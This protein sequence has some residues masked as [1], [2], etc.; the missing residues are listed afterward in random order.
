MFHRRVAEHS[1][2]IIFPLLLTP[3][4]LDISFNGTG[5]LAREKLQPLR[6]IALSKNSSKELKYP[7]RCPF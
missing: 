3:V 5:R 7:H 2:R 6:G 4:K 1:E